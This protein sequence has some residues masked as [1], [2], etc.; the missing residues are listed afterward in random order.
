MKHSGTKRIE[1]ERLVLILIVL[2]IVLLQ[3]G[4]CDCN[5]KNWIPRFFMTE[6][7]MI[8]LRSNQIVTV[9]KNGDK[10]ALKALFSK[11]A[12]DEADSLDE[13]IDAAFSFIQGDIVTWDYEVGTI[14]KS[15]EYGKKTI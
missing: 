10:D 4:G 9:L 5:N 7:K 15:V 2:S 12:V 6:E 13:G 11:K 1:T 14:Y 3:F 8:D